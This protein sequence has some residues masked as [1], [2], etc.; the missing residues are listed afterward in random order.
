MSHCP[1]D[2]VWELLE[3]HIEPLQVLRDTVAR[4][5]DEG[6]SSPWR[7][8]TADNMLLLL[9]P[10]VVAESRQ[11][12]TDKSGHLP[13]HIVAWDDLCRIPMAHSGQREV[14]QLVQPPPFALH[15]GRPHSLTVRQA[16]AY[17]VWLE[18]ACD[19][20]ARCASIAAKRPAAIQC[21]GLQAAL[22]PASQWLIDCG[23]E[24]QTHGLSSGP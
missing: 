7:T 4:W 21:S 8:E 24:V 23:F 10:D 1:E 22:G 6:P 14:I 12:A 17:A 18:A 15:Y 13:A 2:E 9:D 3:A 19:A 5:R 16:T 20:C 11:P